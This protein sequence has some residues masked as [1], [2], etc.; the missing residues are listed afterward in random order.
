MT[1][2]HDVDGA[3]PAVVLLHSAVCDR[4]MW[5]A[6][7]SALTA[8]GYRLIRCDFQ[9][10][11]RTPA[12][13]RPYNDADDVLGLLDA[14]GIEQAAL[15]ASSYGG[16][17]ALEIAARWPDRV[18]ALALLCAGRPGHQASEELRAIGRREDELLEA[19]DL[20]AAAQL[21]VDT[22]V[23]PEGDAKV[24]D[25][26]REMQRL[27]YEL[28]LPAEEFEPVRAEVDLG[29]VEA[30]CLAVSGRHDMRDFREVA[31]ELPGLLP[32]ARHV[33]LP[34]AGHLPSMERPSE[35]ND[36]LIGFLHENVPPVAAS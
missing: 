23:G 9:G 16:K 14:L 29:R 24:R 20:D 6:Q 2:S 10:F 1:L 35:V 27:A 25:S 36:L 19:G 13:D 4:R 12:A 8:A 7:W 11:G 3:G 22:W 31:A 18:N 17:I 26:V 30:R 33:E 32:D 5:D 28:Q 15:V 21:M 34:W